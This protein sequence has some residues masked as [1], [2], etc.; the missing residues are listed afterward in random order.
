M[1]GAVMVW[2]PPLPGMTA[3]NCPAVSEVTVWPTA[4]ELVIVIF[5]PGLTLTGTVYVKF[6]MVIFAAAAGV[7]AFR[8]LLVEELLVG[9]F[10][11]P[12]GVAL[13]A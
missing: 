8:E 9:G 3:S 6:L 10:D 13:A 2:V 12:D 1:V 7:A 4:S 5:A 11:V